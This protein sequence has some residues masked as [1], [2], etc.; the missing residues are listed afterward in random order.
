MVAV[1]PVSQ[2]KL[3]RGLLWF[4]LAEI[5]TD[6]SGLAALRKRFEAYT[7]GIKNKGGIR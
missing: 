7:G 5:V 3:L 6:P 1:T 2:R 4:D